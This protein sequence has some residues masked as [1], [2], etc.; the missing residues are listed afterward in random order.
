MNNRRFDKR[1]SSKK[2][3][4]II[5]SCFLGIILFMSIGY[6]VLSESL[7]I[8]GEANLY[9]SHDYLWYKLTEEYTNGDDIRFSE[10]R[11]ESGKYSYIGDGSN[12]Y[13]SLNGELWQIIS[14]EADRSI[15]VVKLNTTMNYEFDS[16]NN[17]TSTSTYCDDLIN[18]CNAWSMETSIINNSK[19][20]SVENNSS[21]LSY[22]NETY[23]SS[24][25]SIQDIIE[26][27]DFNIGPVSDNSNLSTIISSEESIKW[28]G[29]IGLLNVSEVLYPSN[30]SDIALGTSTSNFITDYANSNNIVLWTINPLADNTSKV[31]T[32]N[33]DKTQ[34][35]SYAN[36][37]TLS[38]DEITYNYIASPTMYLKNNIKFDNGSGTIDNPFTIQN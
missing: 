38:V 4:Y 1:N 36:S 33:Y 16:L 34:I 31:W 9:A 17:R 3:K 7:E 19:E 2:S 30:I 11:Y 18:G 29:K 22:L 15:K 21:L 26:E 35:P 12:N 20:G 8:N 10:N 25:G 23:Y 27:H 37:T 14:I 6:A 28:N 24:L 5:I 32:I 13:I